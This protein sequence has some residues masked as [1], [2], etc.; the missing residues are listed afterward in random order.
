MKK[1]NQRDLD[2]NLLCH[3]PPDMPNPGAYDHTADFYTH[4]HRPDIQIPSL[5][6]YRDKKLGERAGKSGPYYINAPYDSFDPSTA[7]SQSI[8]YKI[9]GQTKN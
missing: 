3:I 2:K 1:Y 7:F 4:A 5:K 6:L 8:N 9:T